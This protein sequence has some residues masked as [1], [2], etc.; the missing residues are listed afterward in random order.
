MTE[1]ALNRRSAFGLAAGALV[2]TTLRVRAEEATKVVMHRNATCGCCGIWAQRLR[3]AGFAVEI[4]D[5][6]DMKA[7]KTR[8]GVPAELASCHT[9]QI[10]GYVI[11]GHVPVVAIRRLLS[12]KPKAFGLAAPGMASGSPGMETSGEE[13]VF[14]VMLF[15]PA[16]VTSYGNYKGAKAL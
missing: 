8:L 12:E 2:A 14:E 1:F 13:D 16:G 10:G 4:I 7:V 5:E 6:P 11:E 3:E 15:D 9:A